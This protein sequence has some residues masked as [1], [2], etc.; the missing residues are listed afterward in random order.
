MKFNL[1]GP[2]STLPSGFPSKSNLAMTLSIEEVQRKLAPVSVEFTAIPTMPKHDNEIV[3]IGFDPFSGF[4]LVTNLARYTA[5]TRRLTTHQSL[6]V[7]S[8]PAVTTISEPFSCVAHSVHHTAP[9]C[10]SSTVAGV[11]KVEVE[12]ADTCSSK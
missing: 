9:E 6:T 2:N 3:L 5:V 12:A 8:E 7:W 10:P 4:L 11:S 1:P